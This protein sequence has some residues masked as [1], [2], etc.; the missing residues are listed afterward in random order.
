MLFGFSH[1]SPEYWI[2]SDNGVTPTTGDVQVIE[3]VGSRDGNAGELIQSTEAH[4]WYIID[5]TAC[6]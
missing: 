6:Q 5:I 4:G 2:T 3:G 1:T